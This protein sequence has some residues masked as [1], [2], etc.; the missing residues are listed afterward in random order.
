[1]RLPRSFSD[2]NLGARLGVVF[3]LVAT[4]IL[5]VVI[6]G[7]LYLDRLNAEFTQAV[8]ERH[9]RTRLVHGIVEEFGAMSRAVS[10]VLLVESAEEIAAEVRAIDA[11]KR[12]VGEMLERLAAGEHTLDEEKTRLAAVQERN[13]GYLV[14][15]IKFTRLV[16][17]GRLPG[18]KHVLAT[19][20]KPRLEAASVAMRELSALQSTLMEQRRAQAA[21]AYRD[22]RNLT[23]VLA[24]LAV[25]VS[26]LTALWMARRVTAPLRKA[27]NMA[28]RVASG[29]L[30][31][32]I[33]V[34][35]ED[36]TGQ[37]LAA[38]TRMND[39]LTGTVRQVRAGS[40]AIA[41][42]L[43]EL[44]TGN[45]NLMQRTDEQSAALE[46]SASAMQ[47]LTATVKLNAGHARQ[48]NEVAGKAVAVAG[49]GGEV[50]GQVVAT[51]GSINESAKRV[52]D[53]TGVIDGIAFQTNILALNAAVEAARAG[54]QG[55]GFA[56]VAGEVRALAQRSAAAAKEIKGL[57]G[58]SAARVG[59]GERLV[60][61]AGAT[62]NAIVAAIRD[63]TA[64]VGEISN[65]SQ[66]QSNGIDQVNQAIVQME[67]TTQQNAALVEESAAAV[68]SV[69][70]QAQ[71]LVAAVAVF[72]LG[73]APEDEPA[74]LPAEPTVYPVPQPL[75]S[76]GLAMS[77]SVS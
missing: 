73:D 16:D 65:A 2:L 8:A 23:F 26:T 20:L 11:G 25:A 61:E 12:S 58:D 66:E 75:H 48:A 14:S 33:E 55:R 57:I 36:E 72:K 74:S 35:G 45:G 18:A 60:R 53:I 50:M 39:S 64:L 6:A 9:A 47:E 30:T 67:K 41:G 77:L 22:A 27:V 70:R 5:A 1:M 69:E 21:G 7:V 29:D 28:S 19:E 34:K 32:R 54:E 56:V 31:A 63:V 76:S 49:R 59:D 68:E 17:S 71:G 38:L 40:D 3:G 13:S 24:L 43:A 46:E 37:L 44:V 10:N 15:L 51:M 62:M 52:Q 4:V 42:A